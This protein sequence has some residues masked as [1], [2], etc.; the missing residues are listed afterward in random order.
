MGSKG[1]KHWKKK[2][3]GGS[4]LHQPISYTSDALESW[5]VVS[6]GKA[7]EVCEVL[8]FS[9]SPEKVASK[10]EGYTTCWG[11]ANFL[12]CVHSNPTKRG[13]PLGS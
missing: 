13:L 6:I 7:G 9:Y 8:A 11:D 10:A 4:P 1:Y 12:H 2:V 5:L 3:C